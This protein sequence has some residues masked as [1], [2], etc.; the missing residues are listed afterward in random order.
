MHFDICSR[1][2]FSSRVS[3]LTRCV[4]GNLIIS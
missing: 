1:F 4:K 3:K 2:A